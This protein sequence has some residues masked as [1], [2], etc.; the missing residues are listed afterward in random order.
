MAGGTGDTRR[1]LGNPF[2]ARQARPTRGAAREGGLGKT[3][4]PRQRPARSRFGGEQTV[5][6]CTR[7]AEMPAARERSSKVSVA[8]GR[9]FVGW[10]T[11]HFGEADASLG[12]DPW[13]RRREAGRPCDDR[14]DIPPRRAEQSRSFPRND[15][16]RRGRIRCG[17]RHGRNVHVGWSTR[18]VQSSD[19]PKKHPQGACRGERT[20]RLDAR[21][22]S[23]SGARCASGNALGCGRCEQAGAELQEGKPRRASGAV[24][25][26]RQTGA[27]DSRV[28]Q[29]L[30]VEPGAT[31]N[32]E[33]ARTRGDARNGCSGGKGSGGCEHR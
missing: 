9:P 1:R 13:E 17:T 27:T 21:S 25:R 3:P 14:L 33:G 2:G 30:E 5:A 15:A 29:G 32:D 20:A 8:N 7:S 28:E 11:P 19:G 22:G 6:T 16:V 12:H 26:Q 18:T 31:G 4:G 24:R 23:G 10:H